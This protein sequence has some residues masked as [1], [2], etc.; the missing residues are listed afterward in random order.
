MPPAAEQAR[1]TLERPLRLLKRLVSDLLDVARIA[2]D[3]V[4]LRP[5]RI[6]LATV[7]ES[8]VESSRLQVDEHVHELVVTLPA[9][10]VALDADP[11]RL[12][13]VITNLLS[14]AAKFTPNGGQIRL[15][16]EVDDAA[17]E[18]VISVRDTG[19]GIA[20]DQLES[21]FGMFSQ[22][23]SS[24]EGA[25]GG[26]GV[27]LALAR[28]LTELHG[29][30]I[31][32][33]SAGTGQGSEFLVRLPMVDPRPEGQSRPEPRLT[34]RAGRKTVRRASPPRRIL[35]VDDNRDVATSMGLLLT[36]LGHEVRLAHDGP[37]ALE[38]TR[39]FVPD[40][41]LVDVGLPGIDGYE[42]ARRMRQQPTLRNV[43]LVALTGWGRDE[44]RRR[45]AEAGFD[46]H[47]VKPVEIEDLKRVLELA[48]EGG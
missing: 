30:S 5:K 40:V 6:S 20:T 48:S 4:Q 17:Q 14:N 44:D 13:Q 43:L 34:A 47:L 21:I 41:A 28:K 38:A 35:V 36:I 29:G 45:S 27:G 10:A 7:V 8:A 9:E 25:R 33:R 42:V 2:E 31:E 46:H 11:V 1:E 24:L 22:G 32:A 19:I 12:G 16:A 39:E 37:T 15:S 23:S 18:V 3:K 26:L